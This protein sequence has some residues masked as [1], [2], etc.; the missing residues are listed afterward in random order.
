MMTP[1]SPRWMLVAT[2]ASLARVRD[3]AA[4]LANHAVPSIVERVEPDW[5]LLVTRDDLPV[6]LA[7]VGPESGDDER[8]SRTLERLLDPSPTNRGPQDWARVS[9]RTA[10]GSVLAFGVASAAIAGFAAAP[11]AADA[12]HWTESGRAYHSDDNADGSI[13]RVVIRG[14]DGVPAAVW[15]DRD[16]DGVLDRFVHFDHRTGAI[17]ELLDGDRD[18]FPE[19]HVQTSTGRQVTR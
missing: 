2:D 10:L 19:E 4:E 15:I 17:Q 8:S 5:A 16:L 14:A 11:T 6:A 3:Q 18:G 9:I 12:S 13:D 7:L 1:N